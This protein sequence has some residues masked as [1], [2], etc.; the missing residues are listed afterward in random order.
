MEAVLRGKL[1]VLSVSKMKLERAYRRSLTAHLNALEQK[2]TSTPVEAFP[3]CQ[4]DYIWNELQ[5][6]IGT[7]TSDPNLEAE[8]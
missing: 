1:I 6:R 7:L 8:R 3:G 2:E 5:S 4:L